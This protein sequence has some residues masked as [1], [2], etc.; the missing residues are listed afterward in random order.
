MKKP[1]K[2]NRDAPEW[3]NLI[4]WLV[5]SIHLYVSEYGVATEGT[6]RC[7]ME[8][9]YRHYMQDTKNFDRAFAE[10]LAVCRNNNFIK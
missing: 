4:A 9:D 2:F 3:G 7:I 1:T 8:A 6:A 5:Y 10:A